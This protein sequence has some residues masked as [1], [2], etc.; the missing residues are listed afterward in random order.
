M[1]QDLFTRCCWINSIVFALLLSVSAIAADKPKSSEA[2][3][4]R[5]S[6]PK[7]DTKDQEYQKAL[8]AY[9]SEKYAQALE[10]ALPLASS[11]HAQA[12]ELLGFIYMFGSNDSNRYQQAMRWYEAA[13]KN[14]NASTNGSINLAFIYINGFGGVQRN[15]ER[16][17]K[18]LLSVGEDK[19]AYYNLAKLYLQSP[20]FISD[21][22]L[23]R[24]ADYAQRAVK[25]GSNDAK[26][27]AGTVECALNENAGVKISI[28]NQQSSAAYE[29]T[30]PVKIVSYELV[31]DHF[32]SHNGFLIFGKSGNILKARNGSLEYNYYYD[33]SCNLDSEERYRYES[34]DLRL[35]RSWL[36]FNNGRLDSIR[37]NNGTARFTYSE[38]QDGTVFVT[39]ESV[40]NRFGGSR[41][42]HLDRTGRAFWSSDRQFLVPI[43]QPIWFTGPMSW[44]N[45]IS[46]IEPEIRKN[47]LGQYSYNRGVF[48]TY[49]N[50]GKIRQV[51]DK[52]SISGRVRSNL[53]YEYGEYG[54][55]KSQNF[56][57]YLQADD[58]PGKGRE[59][60]RFYDYQFDG[61]N[62]WTSRRQT[63]DLF[64]GSTTQTIKRQLAYW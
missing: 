47:F 22:N 45:D 6:K 56:V 15:P 59:E 37:S 44:G 9:Q 32:D 62:N 51:T 20:E 39:Q 58:T 13:I 1:P 50:D 41:S 11:G 24:A 35:K 10:A 23:R 4:E 12:Q 43:Y 14:G 52:S 54:V 17:E 61:K 53:N 36:Y 3:A 16:A 18:L 26:K 38:Q 31:G 28:T 40:N 25:L 64:S 42:E 29:V 33:A 8:S 48:I 7:E 34:G 55:L 63:W 57:E 5:Q 49:T 27:I 21:V 46:Y 19:T 30:G 60:S 2:S